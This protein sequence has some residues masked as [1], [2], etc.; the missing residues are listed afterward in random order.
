MDKN[1]LIGA[2]NEMLDGGDTGAYH[3]ALS[4]ILS[5]VDKASEAQISAA[6]AEIS[7]E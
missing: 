4:L 5:L 1:Q 7:T 2:I 6:W 3:D